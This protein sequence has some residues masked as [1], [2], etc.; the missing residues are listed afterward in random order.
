MNPEPFMYLPLEDSKP[1]SNFFERDS[2]RP[3]PDAKWVGPGGGSSSFY[4]VWSFYAIIATLVFGVVA[5]PLM[6]K[7][8]TLNESKVASYLI[9]A[10][11]IG[12]AAN[13]IGIAVTSQ[14]LL[15]F[16]WK[17]LDS[18]RPVAV[19]ESWMTNITDENLKVHILP[20]IASLILLAGVVTV[21]WNGNRRVLWAC[22]FAVPLLFFVVWSCVPI[23]VRKYSETKT[24]PWNKV[25]VVYNYPSAPIQLALPVSVILF[26]AL[27]IY[28]MRGMRAN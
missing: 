21:P 19:S 27:M 9:I 18:E 26:S 7:F 15:M 16:N 25:N 10:V 5:I 8:K 2:C 24:K 6:H 23:Q 11:I 22:S 3:D 4:T 20:I 28:S 1:S 14:S 12:F 13:S 17:G